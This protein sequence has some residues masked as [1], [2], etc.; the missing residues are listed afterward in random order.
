MLSAMLLGLLA[1]TAP[2]HDPEP[3]VRIWFD[4]K[5]EAYM[6]GDRV[7]VFL[8]TREDGYIVVFHVDP[9]NRLRVLFPLDPSDD[10]YVKG[11]KTYKI[12]NRGGR[13]GFVADVAGRGVVFAAASSGPF[14]FDGFVRNDFWDYNA[15]NGA[16]IEGDI[17]Q[18]L[19][20]LTQRMSTGRF[21][22]DVLRY[23]AFA[24]ASEIAPGSDLA[25][26][27][28]PYLNGCLGCAP[29]GTVAVS[30]GVPVYCTSPLYDPDCYDP[31]YWSPGYVPPSYWNT[32]W[33]WYGGY[34]YPQPYYG[35]AYYPYAPYGPVSPYQ[36][37]PWNRQWSGET[38]GYRPRVATENVN[39]VV[40]PL[41]GTGRILKAD[42][43]RTWGGTMPSVAPAPAQG[44]APAPRP[45]PAPSDDAV[46][47]PSYSPGRDSKPG[48]QRPPAQ[49]AP[50]PRR[51]WTDGGKSGQA[52]PPPQA[53][54]SK[55]ST[56]SSGS[57]GSKPSQPSTGGGGGRRRG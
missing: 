56:G 45:R 6:R 49:E 44:G 9:D 10:N 27:V 43:R 40:G 16:P 2:A 30:Y 29:A 18:A 51:E 52:S 41:P 8:K 4:R 50:K 3:P 11:G 12:I 13:E 24:D 25:Y 57:A 54:P 22:Y 34:Y 19:V 35:G 32:G 37:K 48:Q 23:G 5:D 7:K 36:P 14:K 17:E 21:D 20:E 53:S 1:L 38:P 28:E 42:P 31:L 26:E 15:L 39:T 47:P 33:G 46:E 55:G